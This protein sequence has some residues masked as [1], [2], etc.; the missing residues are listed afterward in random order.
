[1]QMKKPKHEQIIIA[2]ELF[3]ETYEQA[4]TGIEKAVVD[5]NV[6]YFL[7]SVLGKYSIETR[8]RYFQEYE[9]RKEISGLPPNQIINN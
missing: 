8:E 2:L 4:N 5:N 9:K 3:V 1:M 6:I 7:N